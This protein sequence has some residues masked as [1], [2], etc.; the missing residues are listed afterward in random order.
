M[1][2]TSPVSV[3]MAARA[4]TDARQSQYNTHFTCYIY[5]YGM[6]WEG[7]K[8][9]VMANNSKVDL[10]CTHIIIIASQHHL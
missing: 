9:V 1:A 6:G 8:R 4:A 3:R 2:V 5:I 7:G 10:K